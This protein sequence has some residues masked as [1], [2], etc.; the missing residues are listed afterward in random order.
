MTDWLADQIWPEFHFTTSR[1][2]I[3][4]PLIIPCIYLFIYLLMVCFM[5]PSTEFSG[6]MINELERMWNKAVMAY[7]KALSWHSLAATKENH[8]KPHDS[9]CPSSDLN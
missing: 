1:S 2:A 6:K 5:M 7:L 4:Q 3:T 8:E 9:Q